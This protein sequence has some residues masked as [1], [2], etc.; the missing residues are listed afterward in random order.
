MCKLNYRSS[1][2]SDFVIS[3]EKVIS[4]VGPHEHRCYGIIDF[5]R[6]L[7]KLDKAASSMRTNELMVL[8]EPFTLDESVP[9]VLHTG[10]IIVKHEG[11][12]YLGALPYSELTTKHCQEPSKRSGDPYRTSGRKR[13]HINNQGQF[14]SDKYP[15]CPA[16]KV[17]LSVKDPTAQ[18]LLWE[19]AQRR[20]NVDP[21]FSDDLELALREAG[22]RLDG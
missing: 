11:G 21:E 6:E 12:F 15:T 10:S 3:D 9:P 18:D 8:H 1:K 19:Y 20:R 17:P 7:T 13:P 4:Y 16:G 5:H 2:R 22:Y 14:Q